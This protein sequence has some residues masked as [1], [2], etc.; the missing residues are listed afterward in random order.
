[1]AT[2]RAFVLL[3]LLALSS[4]TA[5]ARLLRAHSGS[6]S[7]LAR[8][9]GATDTEQS[10]ELP[11]GTDASEP[12]LDPP[13]DSEASPAHRPPQ[14]EQPAAPEDDQ[15]VGDDSTTATAET[16][17]Q[18]EEQAQ[19]QPEADPEEQ[20]PEAGPADEAT[21]SEDVAEAEQ[22]HVDVSTLGLPPADLATAAAFPEAPVDGEEAVSFDVPESED[23]AAFAQAAAASG[24][25][26]TDA[27]MVGC[28]PPTPHNV[29]AYW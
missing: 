9:T 12:A 29:D 28:H 18:P 10:P 23:D 5:S 21:S 7:L 4:S 24:S 3:V 17:P 16:S 2:L 25:D 13:I 11:A 19:Q 20:Q 1:M 15:P 27:P 8:R 22:E 26:G 6:G 14:V